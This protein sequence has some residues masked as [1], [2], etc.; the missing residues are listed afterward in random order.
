M[1]YD[2][3]VAI[4]KIFGPIWMMG[5]LVIVAIRAYA[6]SRRK[7]HDYAARSIL[8]PDDEGEGRS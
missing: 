1:S 4:A 5:F 7:A 8:L 2:L 3:L 6:P